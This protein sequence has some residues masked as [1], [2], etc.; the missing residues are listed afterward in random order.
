MP[1]AEPGWYP[2]PEDRSRARYWDGSSWTAETRAHPGAAKSPSGTAEPSPGTPGSRR[3]W[4]L[5]GAVALAAVA[6]A[7]FLVVSGGE[8]A[9]AEVIL[10]PAAA[11][12][13]DP[14][15]S[16]VSRARV[17]VKSGGVKAFSGGDESVEAVRGST[18][19]L[20]GGT[21]RAAVCDPEALI[22]F[23]EANPGKG[24]AFGGVVGVAP[25][26]LRD[27]I[28]GLT[29]VVLR[30]DTRVTNHGFAGGSA[31]PAQAVLQ[32]GTAVLVDDR[33]VP[34]VRCACG[35]PLAEPRAVSAS[36][37]FSGRRWEGFDEQRLVA[38]RESQRPIETFELVDV[39]TGRPYTVGAGAGDVRDLVFS[40]GRVGNLRIGMTA[41]QARAATGIAVVPGPPP[42]SGFPCRGVSFPSLPALS[43]LAVNGRTIG[44]LYSSDPRARTTEGIRVGSSA[45]EIQRAYPGRT[46]RQPTLNPAWEDVYVSSGADLLRFTIDE[47]DRVRVIQVGR[48]PDVTAAEGC[49]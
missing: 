28:S 13:E 1:S 45:T 5:A 41:A 17:K 37:R 29:P 7:G 47:S 40:F 32:A 8:D 9:G 25:G 4:I 43:G 18:P 39:R 42:V 33:G 14:F 20:Y 44:A 46:R 16:S 27:Y 11:R 48:R 2:D 34:R 38:I 3:S 23:L 31:R 24:R 30:E 22:R 10:E 12:G 49:I 26:E 6:V 35:N 21:G 36:P 15:T 19:Q